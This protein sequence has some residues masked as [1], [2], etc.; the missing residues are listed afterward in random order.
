M[1]QGCY[2]IIDS[3]NHKNHI[4]VVHIV[5][6]Q[7][8]QGYVLIDETDAHLLRNIASFCKFIKYNSKHENHVHRIN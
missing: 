3:L 6:M 5:N 4:L 2:K 8:V 1:Y 7:Y